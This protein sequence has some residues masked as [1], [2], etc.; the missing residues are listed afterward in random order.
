MPAIGLCVIAE[1]GRDAPKATVV[2]FDEASDTE[3]CVCDMHANKLTRAPF[4]RRVASEDEQRTRLL[5]RTYG[6]VHRN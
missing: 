4:N 3:A 2:L 6:Y 5:A 1:H